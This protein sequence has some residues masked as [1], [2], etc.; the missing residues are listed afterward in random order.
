[1]RD[2]YWGG[3]AV[4]GTRHEHATWC[5]RSPDHPQYADRFRFYP[6]GEKP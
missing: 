6:N 3:C 4:C 2:I 1:M 5:N